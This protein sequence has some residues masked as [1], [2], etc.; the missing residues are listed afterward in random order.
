MDVAEQTAL[1]QLKIV[2][3]FKRHLFGRIL[4]LMC[5]AVGNIGLPYYD[6]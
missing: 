1:D 4:V 5:I 2:A 6:L 3:T